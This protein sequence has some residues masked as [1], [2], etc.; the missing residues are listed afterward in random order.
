MPTLDDRYRY[1]ILLV[2]NAHPTKTDRLLVGNAHPTKTANKHP[3]HMAARP[4]VGWAPPTI[5]IEK[6]TLHG[7]DDFYKD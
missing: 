3:N 4:C 7:A 1:R 2:G 5:S 6:L